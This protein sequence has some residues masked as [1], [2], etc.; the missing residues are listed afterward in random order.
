M[1]W[2]PIQTKLPIFSGGFRPWRLGEAEA[3]CIGL[4]KLMGRH[5]GFIAM[6]AALAA[7]DVDICREPQIS[8]PWDMGFPRDLMWFNW[9]FHGSLKLI[10]CLN[11]FKI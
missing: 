7:R 9:I 2:F 1:I 8:L 6:N 11:L 3:N 4:V 5:C 10:S